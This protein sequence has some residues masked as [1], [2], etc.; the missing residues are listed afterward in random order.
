ME[1]AKPITRNI[2][3]L[4]NGEEGTRP[5][6]NDAGSL[7][8]S[9]RAQMVWVQRSLALNGCGSPIRPSDQATNSPRL[10]R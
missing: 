7:A 10:P 2:S 3:I 1:N 8:G 6:L 4:G 9:P 5:W